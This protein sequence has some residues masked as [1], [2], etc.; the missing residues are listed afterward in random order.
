VTPLLTSEDHRTRLRTYRNAREFHLSILGGEWPEIVSNW[1]A[2]LR[3]DF[4]SEL[5]VQGGR[6]DIA[7]YFALHDPDLEVRKASIR[8]LG[9]MR[10]DARLIWSAIRVEE[11]FP[12]L[13]LR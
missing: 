3:G 8:Y 7:E 11:S 2:T 1:P 10:D 6:T 5:T 9:W 12:S 13:T 4:V